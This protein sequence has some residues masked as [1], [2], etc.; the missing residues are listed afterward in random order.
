MTTDFDCIVIGAG[1]AG[2][3]AAREIA[4]KG[5]SVALM[6]RNRVPGNPVRCGEGVGIK[7]MKTSIGIR[8]HWILT[9]I[10]SVSFIAPDETE[11]SLKDLGPESYCID[12]TIMDR[13]LMEDARTAGARYINN[14]AIT[15]ISCEGRGQHRR[16]ICHGAK[17]QYSAPL[18]IIADGVESRLKRF[19]G[20]DYPFSMEDMESCA[21]LR[22]EHS[23]ITQD[24]LRFFVGED[25]APGGYV[26]V[27]P[28]GEGIANVGLGILGT[29][30]QP[31]MARKKLL[32]F[33]ETHYPGGTVSHF[34][35]GGVPVAAHIRPLVKGGVLL[36]GD[37][38]GQV[39]ALNGGGIAYAL[40]AGREAGR[41][42]CAAYS[43]K[44]IRFGRLKIYEKRWNTYCGKNQRRSYALKTAL[45]RRRDTFFNDLAGSLA[46]EDPHRLNYRNVFLR[47]FAKH[48]VLLFKTFFLFR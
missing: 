31:G 5:L 37:C 7:G 21:F 39:N 1:P 40:Y 14:T 42:V 33:I 24:T 12:R 25:R 35:C 43:G 3:V 23:K 34:H 30:S 44:K 19:V 15:E 48:P 38:A 36:A 26:W 6:E 16:Y 22:L 20:W 29:S 10:D 11:V 8:D 17:N 47:V 18:I 32:D 45:L 41:A 13:E 9:R 28:R 4:E 46:Q 2:S 27:F